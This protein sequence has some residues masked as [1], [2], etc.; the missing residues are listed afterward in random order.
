M[1]V[2]LKRKSQ[3]GYKKIILPLK[4]GTTNADKNTAQTADNMQ[5]QSNDK[6]MR[7]IVERKLIKDEKNKTLC[8]ADCVCLCACA[9]THVHVCT[10]LLYSPTLRKFVD[11]ESSV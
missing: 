6:N 2:R 4:K 8:I 7:R 5:T 9:L 3:G 1:L 11:P 10:H